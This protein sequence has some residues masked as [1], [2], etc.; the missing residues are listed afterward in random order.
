MQPFYANVLRLSKPRGLD[1]EAPPHVGESNM[2][3]IQAASLGLGVLSFVVASTL[4]TAQTSG[5]QARAAEAAP[6]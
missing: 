4:A 3:R 2:N 6:R 5:L 1:F